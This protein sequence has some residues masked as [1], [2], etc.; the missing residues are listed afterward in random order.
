MTNDRT[1]MLY[2][3]DANNASSLRIFQDPTSQ[4]RG[5]YFTKSQ[6]GK[7]ELLEYANNHAVYFLFSDSDESSVYVG[8]T[9]NG[10]KRIK[11]HLREKDFWQFGILFVTDNN[12][13]DK[14]SI[15]YLEYYFIQ[16]FSKTQYSLE[17]QDL[18]TIAPNV[19][20]F[21]QSTLNSFATQIQFLLEALGISFNP[22]P[23]MGCDKPDDVEIFNAR[24]PYKASIRLGDGKF[25]LQ[26][27]SEIKAPLERTKEWNDGGTFYQRSFRRYNQLIESG[28]AIK[29]DE[30][31]AKLIDDV[32]FNS[33]STP[34]ELCSGR[35]QNGWVFW[36]GLDDKRKKES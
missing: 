32:E 5:F 26:Q 34:A 31:T 11:S 27:N 22:V 10:I 23:S 4:I 1:L 9:V 2:F 33:P 17:N 36:I 29:I 18:R 13:F 6:L 12:S 19:N 30:N 15:D 14:L 20:V 28:K 8:Q 21:N 35:S 7:V 24:T 3:P 16:A 25:I